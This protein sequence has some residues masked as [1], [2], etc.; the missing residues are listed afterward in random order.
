MK[1]NLVLITLLFLSGL[2]IGQQTAVVDT[3]V[4]SISGHI[5]DV[6]NYK[7]GL[8]YFRNI[9][10]L[11][12]AIHQLPVS[13]MVDNYLAAEGKISE[14]LKLILSG[15][16]I[17]FRER[18][19]IVELNSD[20]SF[21]LS[22]SLLTTQ[23]GQLAYG[24]NK[25]PFYISPGDQ[26]QFKF[27]GNSFLETLVFFGEGSAANNYLLAKQKHFEKETEYLQRQMKYATPSEFKEYMEEQRT[28]RLEFLG[29]YE[30]GNSFEN[31]F[32]DFAK[33]EINYWYANQLLSYPWEH[34]LHHD[35]DAPMPMPEDYF[36]FLEQ[37]EIVEVAALPY[38]GYT[39]F[40]DQYFDYLL[41]LPSNNSLT[42]MQLAE[43][44]L[45]GE[46]LSFYK[47]RLLTI[48]CKRGR[49]TENEELIHDFIANSSN[50]VYVKVLREALVEAKGLTNGALAPVFKLT[51][52]NGRLVSLEDFKEKVVYLDF[53]ASWCS[54][55]IMQMKNSKSWKAQFKDKDVAFIYI[56]LDKDKTDWRNFVH[57]L[58]KGSQD[59]HLVAKSGEMY[60][61][62]VARE[63]FV[64]RLPNVFII[65]KQGNVFYN[66]V[67]EKTQLRMA[68]MIEDLL[69]V[70]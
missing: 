50:E 7:I 3:T 17:T 63:Y 15:D 5:L 37:L 30:N 45:H 64:K 13:N 40:L 65:D 9:M 52:T 43:Q 6:K 36:A 47:A 61:S 55:C 59:V 31:D 38:E 41:E 35:M 39:H 2:V 22:L 69:L 23:F 62:E 8:S 24:K 67:K 46:V 18:A 48:A 11:T 10:C 44:N 51:N 16:P 27:N 54:P 57:S 68:D 28:L 1:K 26:L 14:E 70:N 58:S 34:P 29:N 42:K 49:A 53:W 20:N 60:D 12:E 32:S 66:S 33:A 56:S 19:K 21:D 25:I 4:S